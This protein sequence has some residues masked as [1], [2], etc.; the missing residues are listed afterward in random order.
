MSTKLIALTG[1]SMF[2]PHCIKMI[3][4]CIG[5]NFVLL[6]QDRMENVEEWLQ[7]C[8]GVVVAGGVDMHPTL[9][10]ENLQTQQGLSKFDYA[11]DLKEL[12]V[13]DYCFQ[14][15]VPVL[16]ICRGHQ[17]MSVYKGLGGDFIMD[18]DGAVIHQPGKY[19]VQVA[20]NEPCHAIELLDPSVFSVPNPKERSPLQK[21]LRDGHGKNV[22]WV[23]SWHHQG[24]EY[25]KKNKELYL[26][27]NIKVLATA[28]TGMKD[29]GPVIELMMGTGEQAHWITAQFH[30]ESDW[31]ENTASRQ[32]IEMFKDMLNKGRGVNGK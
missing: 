31:E 18:L 27:N 12:L 29:V 26:K 8:D 21:L 7:K 15:K 4:G 17:L 2:T 22:A 10:A 6:Y 24:V 1:P 32:V 16:G 19:Q 5:A 13:I 11:R 28:D 9:Y 20:Q 25:V 3:E 23:N 30:P 14:N